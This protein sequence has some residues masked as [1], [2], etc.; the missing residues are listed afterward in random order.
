MPKRLF[1]VFAKEYQVNAWSEKNEF[2]PNQV[3]ISSSKIIKFN[4]NKCSH[5]FE[6]SLYSVKNGS[7]CPY[8]SKKNKKI[9][10]ENSCTSCFEKSFA[11]FDKDKVNCWSDKNILKP[12]EVFKLSLI[13]I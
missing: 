4:C 9:C 5:E 11:S 12:F 2:K 3:T 6:R 10:G 1:S 13:H 8:C 7:W